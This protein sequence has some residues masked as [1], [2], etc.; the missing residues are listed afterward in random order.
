MSTGTLPLTLFTHWLAS[1]ERGLSSE[2][3]VSRLTGEKVG[4]SYGHGKDYPHDPGDFRR[5][6][7]LLDA[8][9]LARLAFPAMREVSPQWARLVDAWDDI[10]A[11]IDSKDAPRGYAYALMQAVIHDGVVCQSCEGTGN[12][13]Q[14]EKCKGSGT[15]A[16]GR[17]AA[18]FNGYHPCDD[19]HGRGYHR[20]A[21]T[22]Q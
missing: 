19:C 9:P 13:A 4:R 14:C 8:V 6:Q 1:G 12:G 11:A 21:V 2:A 15:R 5:C 16:G 17:C 10:A 3:I 7:K 22:H 18:C 20:Q